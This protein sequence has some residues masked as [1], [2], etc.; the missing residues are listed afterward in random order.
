MIGLTSGPPGREDPAGRA[1]DEER[2]VVVTEEPTGNQHG[3]IRRVILD[4]NLLDEAEHLLERAVVG[5]IHDWPA[6]S[7]RATT[8]ESAANLERATA[9][10]PTPRLDDVETDDGLSV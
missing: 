4:V 5:D 9:A 7:P 8:P 10:D 3:V 2:V 1:E 6:P